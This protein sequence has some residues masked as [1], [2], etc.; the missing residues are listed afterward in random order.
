MV[1]NTQIPTEL[2]NKILSAIKDEANHYHSEWEQVKFHPAS[3]YRR[4]YRY[5]KE[6]IVEL[7]AA[8]KKASSHSQEA[9]Y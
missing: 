9:S 8:I 4:E 1:K 6:L 2:V 3:R 7:E 5:W